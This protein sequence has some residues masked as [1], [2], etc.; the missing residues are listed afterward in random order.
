MVKISL[1]K[2]V[3]CIPPMTIF[4]CGEWDLTVLANSKTSGKVPENK[5]FI[6]TRSGLCSFKLSTIIFLQYSRLILLIIKQ[7]N[8]KF[9]K[10]F[11]NLY[12]KSNIIYFK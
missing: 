11:T 9:N 3:G 10:F 6:P 1:E 7:Y 8:I 2:D 4:K 5:Q 12:S